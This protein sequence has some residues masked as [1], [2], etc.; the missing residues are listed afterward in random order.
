MVVNVWSGGC[1]LTVGCTML[2]HVLGGYW[3]SNDGTNEDEEHFLMARSLFGNAVVA[4]ASNQKRKGEA[5]SS[6]SS[7]V[8]AQARSRKCWLLATGRPLTI[9]AGDSIFHVKTL[10]LLLHPSAYTVRQATTHPPIPTDAI[11]PS[12]HPPTRDITITS[13]RK[14]HHGRLCAPSILHSI[15]PRR[16]HSQR[17]RPRC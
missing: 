7:R 3:M 6:R 5:R 1:C 9:G 12:T 2:R 17:Y 11:S 8:H 15:R 13:R 14:L 4:A 10:T 16:H